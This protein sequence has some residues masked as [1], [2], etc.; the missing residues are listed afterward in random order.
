MLFSRKRCLQY[1]ALS[2][3]FAVLSGVFYDASRL[4]SQVLLVAA[5]PPFAL[6]VGIYVYYKFGPGKY[7][8]E[9]LRELVLEGQ[10]DGSEAEY[11][12]PDGDLFCPCCQTVYNVKFRV[13][14]TCATR[15]TRKK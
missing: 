9:S 6:A 5:V 2:A 4:F 13:C 3:L 7:D 11:V 8:L 15:Q 14:P 12:D 10:F 1:V